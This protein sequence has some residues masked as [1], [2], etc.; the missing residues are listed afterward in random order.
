MFITRMGFQV[1]TSQ[2]R[3]R[4]GSASTKAPLALLISPQDFQT[5]QFTSSCS[6]GWD[7]RCLKFSCSA[8]CQGA[9]RNPKDSWMQGIVC[10]E[11]LTTEM[12][13]EENLPAYPF[14]IQV[15]LEIF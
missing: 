3:G 13:M 10:Q 12:G 9:G 5:T 15:E 1:G 14:R 6:T 4:E 8:V 7:S 11:E 2:Q